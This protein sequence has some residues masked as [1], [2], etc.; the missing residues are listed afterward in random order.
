MD[1]RFTNCGAETMLSPFLAPNLIREARS[2]TA[3]P[4]FRGDDERED[5]FPDLLPHLTSP[6]C[7][8]LGYIARAA[9]IAV[10]T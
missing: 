4:G 5:G 8:P 2:P 10:T 3:D 7:P 9:S 6:T 1:A